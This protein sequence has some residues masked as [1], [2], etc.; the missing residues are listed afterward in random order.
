[1]LALH[2]TAPARRSP[3]ASSPLPYSPIALTASGLTC[4]CATACILH[5]GYC[6][7]LSW[8]FDSEGGVRRSWPWPCEVWWANMNATHL[9]YGVVVRNF[10]AGLFSKQCCRRQFTVLQTRTLSKLKTMDNFIANIRLPA[11]L[12]FPTDIRWL[13]CILFQLI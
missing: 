11:L 5:E 9:R 2:L 4:V 3:V 6:W 10:V 13:H 12:I 8:G 1:M 7:G